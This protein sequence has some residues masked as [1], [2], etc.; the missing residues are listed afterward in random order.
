MNKTYPS[1]Y[2]QLAY[3]LGS[4]LILIFIPNVLLSIFGIAETHEVW[5]RILGLLVFILSFY[6]YHLAKYGN[7]KT[8]MATVM[9]RLVFCAGLVIYVVV[10]IAPIALIGFA[11]AETALALW[12]WWELKK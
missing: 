4:G 10:G 12:T 5:I 11:V 6:Y 1:L 8:V 3:V 7:P 2:G 9:G